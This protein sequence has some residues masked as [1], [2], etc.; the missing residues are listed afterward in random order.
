[1]E[2]VW[3]ID[4]DVCS[5]VGCYCYSSME[6]KMKIENGFI[7]NLWKSLFKKQ[8]NQYLPD[9]IEAAELE[10]CQPSQIVWCDDCGEFHKDYM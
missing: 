6:F 3:N 10:E 2:M 5:M 8:D 1:M 4:D 7:V 9:V